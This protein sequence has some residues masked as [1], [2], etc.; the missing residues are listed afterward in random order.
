MSP[1]P[2][3]QKSLAAIIVLSFLAGFSIGGII[4]IVSLNLESRGVEPWLIG[5]NTAM[6]P[7]GVLLI[8]PFLP[9]ILDRW[10]TVNTLFCS[11]LVLTSTFSLLPIFTTVNMWLALRFLFG[12]GL[13]VIWI[14]TET[15]VNMVATPKNRGK[16]MG[17]YSTVLASGF[18]IGPLVP[19]ILGYQGITPFFICAGVILGGFIPLTLAHNLAPDL[20]LKNKYKFQFNFIFHLPIVAA[21]A[22]I[23][24]LLDSTTFTFLPIWGLRHGMYESS[25]IAMLTILVT[26]NIILQIPIGALADRFNKYNILIICGIL[27]FCAPPLVH[28]FMNKPLIQGAILFVWGGAFWG[29]YTIGLV[30]IGI[31]FKT[32]ELTIANTSFVIIV[33]IA[34]L[35]SPPA[36][37]IAIDFLNPDGLIWFFCI[38]TVSFVLFTFWWQFRIKKSAF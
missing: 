18:A 21:A 4:P 16:I 15:W 30:L 7:L 17:I 19:A 11:I 36:A 13:G 35:V 10:G 25:A 2:E 29:I 23:A 1:I 38:T 5:L 8:A 22:F 20:S 24:G 27:S 32:K 28:F 37:G 34:T 33:N 31:H 14:V 12:I 3:N 9:T 6:P 26:G